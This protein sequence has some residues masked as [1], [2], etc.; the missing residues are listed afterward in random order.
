MQEF[1]EEAEGAEP[2]AD[3]AADKPADDAKGADHIEANKI[4]TIFEGHAH[5]AE[6]LL[7]SAHGTVG[8]SG[9]AR[10]AVES[11]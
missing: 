5:A 11:R 1:L 3:H 10:V 4:L 6:D 2:A 9:R 8:G 7:E